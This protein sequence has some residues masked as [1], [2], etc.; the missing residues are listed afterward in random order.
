METNF[1]KSGEYSGDTDGEND[2]GW[3]RQRCRDSV[4]AIKSLER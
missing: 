1:R 4:N 2:S 3:Q